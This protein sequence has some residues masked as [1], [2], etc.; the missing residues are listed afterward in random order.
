MAALITTSIV[1]YLIDNLYALL[2]LL[3]SLHS[4]NIISLTHHLIIDNKDDTYNILKWLADL[5]L[6]VKS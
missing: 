5:K 6:E 4:C 1:I 3:S 2:G